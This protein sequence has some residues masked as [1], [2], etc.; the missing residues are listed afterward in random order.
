MRVSASGCLVLMALGAL[1]ARA[2]VAP[3]GAAVFFDFRKG[4]AD[5]AHPGHEPVLRGAR[6][7]KQG[8]E[9]TTAFQLARTDEKHTRALSRKLDGIK[10]MTVGGWFF[11]RRRGEQVF[12][13]RGA[14]EVGPLGE[15]FFRPSERYVNF[16]LGTNAHGFLMGTINGNGRMPF[17]HVTVDDVPENAWSQL[18]IVKDARGHHKFY[19]NGALVHTDEGS[20]WAPKVTPFRETGKG[21]EP[22]RLA[23]PMGGLIAE[24]WV[25]PRELSAEEIA[26]DYRAKK[27]RYR[28]APP[29]KPVLLREMDARP[30]EGLWKAPLTE[31]TWPRERERILAGVRKV[32]GPFPREKVPL[33]PKVHGEVDCGDY[34]RRKVSFAVQP[35]DRMPAYLLVPKK[36]KG[37]VPAV[38]CFY[39]TT[40]GAGKDTTVGL[41]GGKPGT[42][43]EKNRAFALDVVRAGFVALAPDYLR[44]GE[45]IHPGDA[46][47]DTTRFYRKFPDWSVHG[48][49][50]WDTMRAVDYLQSLDFVDPE[51]IG[52]VGHSYGGHS[53]LFAAALEPRIKVAVANGP[54]SSFRGHGLHWAV[55]RGGRNSQSLPAMRPYVLNPDLPLPVTFYE[56][57]SLVAPRALLVGQAVG[58]RRP[59][60]EEN[61]AAVRAV[62]RALGKSERVR[63]HW[64]AGDHDFPPE[65]RRAAV[66]WFRRWFGK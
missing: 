64:Y 2:E 25:F 30:S 54:V 56:F 45:R 57:T 46:P 20:V 16:C 62:Y 59:R 39:G 40:G 33:D 38:I 28:P 21:A 4:T 65:A 35:G 36:R 44:D 49:D 41:S 26:K 63:Y 9:F 15:R 23:M 18:V 1:P 6:P 32:L 12:L 55:P 13:G 14:P 61:H 60:E 31:K 5:A 51:R 8:L 19:H 11:C 52:M 42:A 29:G 7:G 66:E 22:L 58:E 34:V 17:V 47:Y 48:K 43:P 37:R 53:T 3:G 27:A 24:A 10:A 50:V